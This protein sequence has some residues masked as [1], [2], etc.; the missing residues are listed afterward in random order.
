MHESKCPDKNKH[1]FVDDSAINVKG[2]KDF[3][4]KS[5]IHF[6]EIGDEPAA[7]LD[8]IA[9]ARIT[10]LDQLRTLPFWQDFFKKE[11]RS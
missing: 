8:G 7:S 2:A 6:Q 3:G 5:A 9:D 4:W 1:Y 10:D 11:G